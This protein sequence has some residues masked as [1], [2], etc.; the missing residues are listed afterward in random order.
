ACQWQTNGVNLHDGRDVNGSTISGSST[1]TLIITD[2][3]IADGK[4]YWLIAS[5]SAGTASNSMLLTVT[6][7]NFAPVITGLSNQT[8]LAGNNATLSATVSGNPTPALQWYLSTDGGITSNSIAG[9][10]TSTL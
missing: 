7:G 4:T 10:T 8:V 9:Q 1:S 6:Q 5:N 3:Q 2:V